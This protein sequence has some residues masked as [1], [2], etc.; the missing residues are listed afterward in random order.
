MYVYEIIFVL[1]LPALMGLWLDE[2][3]EH[4]DAVCVIIRGFSVM[5]CLVPGGYIEFYRQY[6]EFWC[7]A[8]I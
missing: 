2:Y 3:V 6:L 8:V 4:G 5:F 7:W 1:A